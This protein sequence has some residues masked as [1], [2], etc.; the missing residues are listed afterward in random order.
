[1]RSAETIGKQWCLVF[2]AYSLWHLTC[3][4]AVPGRT[5]SLMHAM[6]DACRQQGRTVLWR[7]LLFVHDQLS[8]GATVAQVFTQVFAKQ[9]SEILV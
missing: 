7:I 3:L 5:W 6:G 2:A 8:R 9:Q 1:M 4:P